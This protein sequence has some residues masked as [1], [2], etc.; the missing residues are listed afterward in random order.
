MASN[1]R[2][3]DRRESGNT[4]SKYFTWLTDQVQEDG[5][6]RNTYGDLFRIMYDT[7]FVWIIPNDDNRLMD[8]LDLRVEFFGNKEMLAK[9]CSALEV[10]VALSRR[11]AWLAGGSAEGWGWQLLCNLEL[12]R[13]RDPISQRKA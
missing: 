7:E 13:F 3:Q 5:H 1:T 6:P 12:H 10:L 8:G 9:P 4:E 11:L 2:T